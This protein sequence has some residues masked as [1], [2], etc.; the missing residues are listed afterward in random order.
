MRCGEMHAPMS[1]DNM[2]LRFFSLSPHAAEREAQRV[3][4]EPGAGHAALLAWLDDRLVGVASYEPTGRPGVA[5]IAF[6]VSDEMHGRGVATLLLEHLV[7]LARQRGLTRVYRRD[8]AR[9]TSPCCGCSPTRAC[10]CSG[11]CADGVVELTFP[12]PAPTTTKQ[13]GPLP[14]VGGAGRAARTWPACGI[15]CSPARSRWSAPAGRGTVG[16]A[17]L[18]NI[19]TG[20]FAGHVYA[21]NPHG[22]SMEGAAL[23]ARRS[24]TCPSRWTSRSSRCPPAAVAEVAAACGRRGVQGAGGDHRGPGRRGRRPAGDL[25][26]VRDAAGRPELLRRRRAAMR[27]ER[28]LRR[29]PTRPARRWRA[30]RAVRRRRHRAARA[31]VQ[32]R[33]R[34]VVVRLGR[35]QV[36]RVQQRHADVVGA[37]RQTR[38]AILYVES[39]GNPR[40]VRPDRPPGRPAAA[41]ADRYGRPVRGGPAAAAS[42]HRRPP[43][44]PL[45]TQ[46][47]L[48]GQAGVIAGRSLGELV[49]AAA[50]LALPAATGR[51]PGRDRLQRGRGR[52]AGR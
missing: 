44:P 18:H 16:R 45:V 27:P 1:P 39:F 50:L 8:A 40:A 21:V 6:A 3:C 13:P 10:R 52:R 31:P 41:G 9:T 38:L 43:R 28:H 29:R 4:R 42:A 14:G 51:Q 15:C 24:P 20:G 17:I 33:H 26:P 49:E 32:A 36:R 47:A 19:V 5:E 2:Y 12:L 48:F 22:R 11:R 7:S 35:R 46:E 23:P 34:G 30:G 25:P 37:G